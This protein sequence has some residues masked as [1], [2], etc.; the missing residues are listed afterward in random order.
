[1]RA[2][3]ATLLVLGLIA[4]NKDADGDGFKADEDCNDNDDTVNEG[5]TEI[6]DGIDNNCDGKVDEGQLSTFFKDVDGDGFGDQN[7]QLAAC[8]PPEGYVAVDSG[9]D[10]D[11]D[12][13]NPA[14]HPGAS[15]DDCTDPVDY[16]CDGST[17]FE[18]ADGDGWAACLDCDD[19]D[20]DRS[21]GATEV[22]DD[23]DNNCNGVVDL[24]A[25]ATPTWYLDYDG[26][27]YGDPT[28]SVAVCDPPAR[29]VS[30]SSD[31]DDSSELALPGG[32]EVCDGYDNDCDGTIDGPD[33]DGALPFY[34]DADGDGFGVDST[35]VY[36]CDPTPEQVV[37]P[38]DCDDTDAEVSPGAT[39]V[40]ND[41]LDN[42]CDGTSEGCE[43]DTETLS[44]AVLRG[45]NANDYAGHSIA[46]VGDLNGDGIDDVVV[47]A[48]GYDNG[49]GEEGA[50]Y[51]VLGPLTGGFDATL[52]AAA[53]I[54][55]EGSTADGGLGDAV[56]GLGDID[57]D[58]LDDFL[59]SAATASDRAVRSGT[60][61]LWLGSTIAAAT[62]GDVIS[63]DDSDA[64]WAGN[65]TYD[66]AGAGLL[67][68]GDWNGDGYDDFAVGATGDDIAGSASGTVYLVLGDGAA[69]SNTTRSVQSASAY[70]VT[71]ES[72]WYIGEELAGGDWDGDGNDDLAFGSF[73]VATNGV[74]A[75]AVF[76]LQGG[77]SGPDTAANADVT[78]N[79]DAAGV[80]AGASVSSAGDLD[81]DG[82]DDLWVGISRDD[83]GGADA[84]A[85]VLVSGRADFSGVD[86]SNLS[87]VV[88]ATLTGSE[89][90]QAVGSVV[91]SNFDWD[92]DGKSDLLIGVPREG[93]NGEG[94][95]YL[96]L[97]F[98][99]GT[100]DIATEAHAIFV[101]DGPGDGVGSEV[102]AGGDVF[103]NGNVTLVIAGNEDDANG[104]DSGGVY[105]IDIIGL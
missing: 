13:A 29:F 85:L 55:L 49:S 14:I 74:L 42:D 36:T 58:G 44:D 48:D 83:G 39:E 62:S 6:C 78:F 91:E 16:N 65:D 57:G 15:E 77:A 87:T 94:E 4:C 105:L 59:V 81:G 45:A 11:C 67:S 86:G 40:C 101:G 21:P 95:S 80:R 8:S 73:R 56:T 90:G 17:G 104:T 72:G 89:S 38:G 24:D 19:S 12:D 93:L 43:I 35:L 53:H 25:S 33:A 75:G 70:Y 100:S 60:V 102:T 88:S 103:G 22:C 71:G 84:G 5:A 2:L 26:D 68:L 46:I 20:G 9:D 30:D 10:F 63:V 61:H 18:D 3:T 97:G 31:C 32:I 92:G 54:T 76:M 69:P 96:I 27:G 82:Y 7:D 23:L 64:R 34:T 50:A 98:E 41:G 28:V 37:D 51:V 52:D 1:M 99:T 79:G 66:W 47:G